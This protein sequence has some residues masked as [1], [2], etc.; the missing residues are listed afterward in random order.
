MYFNPLTLPFWGVHLLA[1][2]G[3]A[4]TGFSWLGLA[5]ALALY[6]PRMFFVTG[7]YHR[8][9]YFAEDLRSVTE[10]GVSHVMR[11]FLHHY[12]GID[13]CSVAPGVTTGEVQGAADAHTMRMTERVAANC[14]EEALARPA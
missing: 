14:D 3:I 13:A 11:L 6:V 4:I 10:E 2:I 1:I 8:G 7:A 12:L 5:W 9:A